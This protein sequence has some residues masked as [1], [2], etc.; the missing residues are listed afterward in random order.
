MLSEQGTSCK[1]GGCPIVP[2]CLVPTDAPSGN[3]IPMQINP[4]IARIFRTV[5]LY[6][7][8]PILRTLRRL[9]VTEAR[10]PMVI[11]TDLKLLSLSQN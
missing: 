9:N 8:C 1:F 7:I 11:Q 4:R 5:R 3:R 6:S 2:S 10:R